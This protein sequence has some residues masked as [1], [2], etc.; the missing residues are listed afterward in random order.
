[1]TAAPR[2]ISGIVTALVTP[3]DATGRLDEAGLQ[4]L[5]V[6]QEAAGVDAIFVLGSVG[7]GPLLDESDYLRVAH[8]ARAGVR[9]CTLLGGASDNSVARCLRRLELLASAGVEYGV[10]TLPY[11]GWPA[12]EAL[13]VDFFAA[14]A[15][16]SPL[17]LVAYNLPKAVGWQMPV[18][19]L[20]KIFPIPNVI[21]IKDTHG[22]FA[23]MAS[24]AASPHRPAH[25]SY[26]PGNSALAP[27]LLG[28]G[29]DGVV[30]TPSNVL[31]APFVDLWRWHRAGRKDRV[32]RLNAEVFP[33]LTG[34]LN[35]APTGA[36]AIK[37]LLEIEGVCARH[38]IPPWPRMS[39]AQTPAWSAYLADLQKT[40]ATFLASV[41]PASGP[42]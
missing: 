14:V 37:G 6:R 32:A 13:S 40:Y 5:L 36:A 1:M 16:R 25:F 33:K 26:L 12:D 38:T 11:Y 15:A 4:R 21:C 9:R 23:S 28:L 18:S 41:D 7:E 22:D 39:D 31:A 34:L 24:V 17:P 29:A 35:L 19:T 2:R 20:E 10:L 42:R 30:S 3:L 8:A 27:R